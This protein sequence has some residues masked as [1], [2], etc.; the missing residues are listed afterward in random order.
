MPVEPHCFNVFVISFFTGEK[1]F[2]PCIIFTAQNFSTNDDQKDNTHRDVKTMK[3]GYHEESRAKL[4]GAHRICP[5]SYTLFHYQFGP[6]KGLH[7]DKAG[8]K[9]R[10]QN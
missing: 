6:L 7:T 9:D 1:P 3:P 2:F 5:G 4:W 10:S 8:A